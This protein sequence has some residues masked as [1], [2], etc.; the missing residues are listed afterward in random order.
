[1][2]P[3]LLFDLS[4]IDLDQVQYDTAA[5]E[6]IIPHRGD[7]RLLDGVIHVNEDWSEA[8]GVKEV[9]DDEFW[10]A[11]HVPGRPLM[12]G[13]VMLETAAQLASFVTINRIGKQGFLGFTGADAV[14]FRGQI[15][16]GDDM[17]LLTKE[18]KFSPRRFVCAVQALVNGSIVFEGQVKGM[19]I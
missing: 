1:M 4:G 17:I 11:G 8:V 12:P 10:V 6:R 13:V 15:V 18:L 14:R 9:R 2:A 19:T 16:P 3:V 5:V 7:M